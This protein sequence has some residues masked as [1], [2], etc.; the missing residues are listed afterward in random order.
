MTNQRSIA[1]LPFQNISSD[2]ENEYFADGMTEELINALAQIEGLK[3]TARTSSF[4]YKKEKKDVRVIGNELGVSTVLEGS[5]RK[6]GERIR[7]TAQL[8]RTDDGFNIWSERFN[9]E[10][11]DIFQLQDEISLLIAEKIRENFGHLEIGE[12]LVLPKTANVEAYQQ[13]LKGRFYQ[14]NW[15]L[16]DFSRA[17]TSYQ[18]SIKLDSNFHQP[19]FGIAQCYFIMASWYVMDKENALAAAD[20]YLKKGL[21]IQPE[22]PEGYFALAT[23][24]FWVNWEAYE[25]LEHLTKAL[26]LAPNDTES[27]EASAECYT[28]LGLFEEALHCIDKALESNPLSANH[29]YTKGNIY[30]LQGHLDKALLWMNKALDI[31]PAWDLALRIKA[32]CFIL[33]KDKPALSSFL[34]AVP[35]LNSASDLML[36][37]QARNEAVK[38]E[39]SKKSS[40]QIVYLPWEVYLPLYNGDINVAIQALKKGIEKRLGQYVNFM[41]DPFLEPLRQ[42]ATF[43]QLCQNTFPNATISAVE[44]APAPPNTPRLTEQEIESFKMAL[45]TTMEEKEA[46]LNP[47]LSLRSLSDEIGLHPNK[48][49]WLLN[50][51]IGQNFSEFVNGYRLSAFQAKTGKPA[52]EHLTILG[53]AYECGYN[54]KTVFNNFFKKTTGM[55]PSAWLRAQR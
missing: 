14:L 5:I 44:P 37:Y 35:D 53:L 34:A 1:V 23:H 10:L 36:L 25:G 31:D 8:I 45:R 30:Y 20:Q 48:L 11:T 51:I 15:N 16:E 22:S 9:R 40:S 49:S 47:D 21:A 55:T 46:Y 50:E 26:A 33:K 38:V 3:V 32:C 2:T 29:C 24:A 54:S 27:L 42:H 39:P 52:Y 7:I 41:N 6:A 17:I 18:L 12:H 43:H 13:F 28:A 4:A 19:Y